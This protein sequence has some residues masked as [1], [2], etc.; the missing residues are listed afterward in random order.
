MKKSL[1]MAVLIALLIPQAFA[2]RTG[3][4]ATEVQGTF[5]RGFSFRFVPINSEQRKN[6]KIKV[7]IC[8]N[9]WL[10]SSREFVPLISQLA[11]KYEKTVKFM[12]A[13][14]DGRPDTERFAK[15]F[16]DLKVSIAGSAKT[17]VDQYMSGSMLYPKA[18]VIDKAGTIVWDGEVIDL[19]EALERITSGKFDLEKNKK[20]SKLVDELQTAMRSGDE[21]TGSRAAEEILKIE[22]GHS[23][24]I[25]LRTFMLE[26]INRNKD[27]Y[28]LLEQQKK[29]LPKSNKIHLYMLDFVLRHEEF[30]DCCTMVLRGL[31]GSD[32][33]RPQKMMMLWRAL[34]ARP[35]DPVLLSYG[36]ESTAA[37][38][39]ADAASAFPKEERR[40]L[41]TLRALLAYRTGNLAQAVNFQT[42]AIAIPGVE[43]DPVLK[44]LLDYYSTAMRLG[45]VK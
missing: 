41:L 16:P 30:G 12:M 45:A 40:L 6:G 27:A 19:V 28:L 38:V 31:D 37:Y 4:R 15:D 14:S 36:C 43:E 20:L 11:Q 21:Q 23:A 13:T 35:L 7:L 1:A 5:V 33:Q 18:F 32:A 17:S 34:L 42:Q 25:R 9:A 26:S 29:L 2:L 3:D 39:Q 8:F 22:P 44:A 24:A 10:E